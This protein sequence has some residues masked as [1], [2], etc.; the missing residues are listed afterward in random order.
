MKALCLKCREMVLKV[1]RNTRKSKLSVDNTRKL[2]EFNLRAHILHE[3]EE[4]IMNS[5]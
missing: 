1:P 3:L 5:V 2:V 4:A